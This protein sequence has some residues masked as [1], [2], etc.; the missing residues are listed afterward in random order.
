MIQKV[1]YGESNALTQNI[2]DISLGQKFA[3]GVIVV[4]IFGLGIMPQPLI[5]L[6][7]EAVNG[8]LAI[9]K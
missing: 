4:F 9:K 1:F 3:L 8:L 2:Q 5:E 6:T 7:K